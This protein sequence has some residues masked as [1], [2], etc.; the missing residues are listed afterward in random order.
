MERK[1]YPH[2]FITKYPASPN[3]LRD[4]MYSYAYATEKPVVVEIPGIN[5]VAMKIPLRSNSVLLKN[6]QKGAGNPMLAVDWQQVDAVARGVKTESEPVVKKEILSSSLPG[7]LLASP[8]EVI[9]CDEK[10]LLAKYQA[11][12]A[13][14]RASKA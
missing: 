14:L 6:A 11:D 1:S 5:A 13:S 2:E 7:L 4:A 10:D 3:D 9:D 8:T 12:L